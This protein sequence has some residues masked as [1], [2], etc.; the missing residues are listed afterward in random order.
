[1]ELQRLVE[2]EG[3]EMLVLSLAGVPPA[4]TQG[5]L[6]P[7][8]REVLIRAYVRMKEREAEALKGGL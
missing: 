7:L 1:M 5:D 3:M 6:T 2:A 8:Q 4:P